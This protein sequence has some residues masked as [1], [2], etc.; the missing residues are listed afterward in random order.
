M[1]TI[2]NS[3]DTGGGDR[4][5]LH[6]VY[7]GIVKNN[8]DNQRMGRL[9]VWIPEIGGDP[10]DESS[11]ITVSYA[12]P[13]AGATNVR[14]NRRGGKTMEDSQQSYGF[15]AVPP[16]LENQVLV[17]FIDGD[18]ARG[19]WF[20]CIYQTRMN[21]M[22]PG[23]PINR[24]TDP[25]WQREGALPPVVEYNKDDPD[26]NVNAPLRPV[27][28][29]L[30]QGLANQGLY[31]DLERGVASTGARREAPSKVFGMLSPR[32]NTI[33]IDDNEANEFIRLRTRSGV[34]ITIHETT[35]YIY[36]ISKNGNSWVEISDAGIDMFTSNSV[37]MRTGRNL[38]VRAEGAIVFDAATSIN[39]R[40][41]TNITME[42]GQS[43]IQKAGLNL[44][45]TVGQ[46]IGLSASGDITL[47]AAGSIREQ[48]SGDISSAAS[49]NWIRNGAT[50]QD[51]SVGAPAVSDASAPTPAGGHI[52]NVQTIVPRMPTHEPWSGHPRSDVPP[53]PVVPEDLSRL[54]AR[55]EG[56]LGDPAPNSRTVRTGEGEDAEVEYR[57]E[58]TRCYSGARTLPVSNEVFTSIRE[59]SDRTGVPFGYLMATAHQ[60]SAFNPNARAR[61]SSATGLFQFIDG[62]W[63]AMVRNHGSQYNVGPGD[64][65]NPRAS[66]LMG[67]EYARQNAQH[68]QR[69]GI[70]AGNAEL[71][72]AHFLGAGGATTMLREYARNPNRPAADVN[73]RAAAANRSVFYRPDGTPRT[74]AEVR[75]WA[76]QKIEPRAQ[77]YAQ[78]YGMP[79]PCDREGA[80][81]AQTTSQRP[82]NTQGPA[83]QV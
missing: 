66:A 56:S 31:G 82:G 23:I 62:T 13:F 14:N 60:E 34:G 71:Y 53:P 8:V 16:D 22:V 2:P 36:L 19:F 3:Y 5:R 83:G 77:A 46:R 17:A 32:G 33:H 52:G 44:V 54:P 78:Q 45:A 35:G 26:I 27:F 75:S 37:S 63:D 30:A 28:R 25:E 76:E 67:A 40:A 74:V 49:G 55:P 11:W 69:N 29:P 61:T 9:A 47:A 79:A 59:A 73:P 43:I 20:A 39:M 65:T 4:I 80:G 58:G 1:N 21:H 81:Q 24:P 42:A 38:N 72:M 41:G 18:V 15:W 50:I 12:A 68:L 70:Q 48:A 51:N 64:R 57:S 6:G 10:E 7:I